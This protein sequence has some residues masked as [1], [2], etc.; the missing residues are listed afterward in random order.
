MLQNSSQLLIAAAIHE[1][2]HAYI[3]YNI[4][5]S[6]GGFPT[7]YNPDGNWFYSLDTWALINGL[8]SN[9]KDHYQMLSDY[10][11]K[12][13]TA[14]A[15]WD[16]NAHSTKEYQEAMLYG[17]DNG[18]DGTP[19]QQSLLQTEF[20]K[21]LTKDTITTT[22]LDIFNKTNLNSVSNKLPTSGCN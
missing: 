8:P 15:S 7:S 17:L 1:T 5:T 3:N 11:D 2:L 18:T 6:V 10:F 19:T 12:A 14:L 16:N 21:I 22:G 20:N 9:Y 4:V 13:V